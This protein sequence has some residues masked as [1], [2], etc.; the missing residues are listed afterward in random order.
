MAPLMF[1]VMKDQ[2]PFDISAY[3]AQLKKY[4]NKIPDRIW[5]D[6]EKE[7]DQPID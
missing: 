4:K 1:R 7:A 3:S 5:S 2:R 6:L